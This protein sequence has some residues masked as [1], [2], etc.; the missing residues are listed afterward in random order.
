MVSAI[1]LDTQQSNRLKA[2][3]SSLTGRDI[4][5]NAVVDPGVGGGISVRI[6]D[7]LIDG[8]VANRMASARRQ[9]LND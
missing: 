5:V 7:D 8:T 2:A 4:N 9:L 3:L 1:A 6:G